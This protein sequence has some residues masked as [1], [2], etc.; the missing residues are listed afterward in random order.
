MRQFGQEL[1]ALID[2]KICK[3]WFPLNNS[4]FNECDSLKFI[5][6]LIFNKIQVEFQNRGYAPIWTGIIAPDR[7]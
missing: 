7:F 1:W 4:S 2:E 6:C 3:F 5:W